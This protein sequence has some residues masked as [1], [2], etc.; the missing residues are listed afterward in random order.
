MR[1]PV[2]NRD[3]P[4]LAECGFPL[5]AGQ[6]ARASPG[7][8][9]KGREDIPGCPRPCLTHGPVCPPCCR[10]GRLQ[11]RWEEAAHTDGIVRGP[12][13][14]FSRQSPRVQAP[15]GVPAGTPLWLS[16]FQVVWG[17]NSFAI[18]KAGTC[19]GCGLGPSGGCAGGVRS[20]ALC[21]FIWV[22]SQRRRI[23]P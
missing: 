13:D 23:A 7:H 9:Q 10:A 16:W 6:A 17:V 22:Q 12:E 20:V 19:R 5:G 11:T 1:T 14:G 21:N 8:S 15:E 3:M 18:W 2:R 4:S